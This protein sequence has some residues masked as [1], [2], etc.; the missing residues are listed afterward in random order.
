VFTDFK[1]FVIQGNV[2]DLAVGFTV[3]AAF[4]TV[5]RS[6]VDDVIMPPVGLVV[7]RVE[8]EDLFWLLQEGD[9]PGP[10][11]TL[12]EAQSVGAVTI[13]Y[14]LFIS[15]TLALVLVGLAM[16]LLI[17]SMARLDRAMDKVLDEPP[18]ED[19]P[20]HKKCPYCRTQI[21]FRA[22]RCPSCTS[23]LEGFEEQAATTTGPTDAEG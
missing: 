3:G 21:D 7:G 16:F 18:P 23:R 22:V 13:N 19:E 17:R 5:A 15:N 6:L 9:R 11:Q 12:T 1:K 20:T 14:G 4:T 2:A 10:Y 8:F